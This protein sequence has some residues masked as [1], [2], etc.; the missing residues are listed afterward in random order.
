[1]HE[2]V[3]ARTLLASTILAG[4]HALSAQA[5]EGGAPAG[6]DEVIVTAQKRSENLQD[7]PM[8]I[9]AIGQ[10]TL[11]NLNV[12]SLDDYV[13][14]LP[15]VSYGQAVGSP[16]RSVIYMRGISTGAAGPNLLPNGQSP[17]VATY[18]DEI[19]T[20]TAS[21]TIDM[22]IYDVARVEALAGPQ[23]TLYGA[24]SEAGTLKIVT[25]PPDPS[26]F[27]AGYDLDGNV[28]RGNGLSNTAEGFINV[29]LADN[30]AIR[31]VG[32]QE[33]D[34][35]YIDNV[36]HTITYPS[37][38]YTV[39]NASLVKKNF[40][41]VDT[42]GGRGALKVDL[43][44][45]WTVLATLLGQTQWTSGFFGYSQNIGV[46]ETGFHLPEKTHDSYWAPALTI[47]GRIA[48]FDITWAGSYLRHSIYQ[49]Q[50]YTDYSFFYDIASGF[51]ANYAYGPGGKPIDVGQS[52]K[53]AFN[54][55]KETQEL[56]FASPA[57]KPLRVQGGLFYENQLSR[58][59]YDQFIHG[60]AP[61]LAVPGDAEAV[62][63][64]RA[65]VGQVDEAVYTNIAY[66]ILP[67][68]TIEAGGR[69]YHYNIENDNFSGGSVGFVFAGGAG[70]GRCIPG[71]TGVLGSPCTDNHLHIKQSGGT[72]RGSV[73][74]KFTDDALVYFTTSD[75]YRPGGVNAN[76][77]IPPY[78]AETLVNYE[79]G[80]K[81]SW[82]GNRL[83]WN[84]DMFYDP[85]SDFQFAFQGPNGVSETV[86][87]G[88]AVSEGIETDLTIKPINALT[89]TAAGSLI[90]AHLTEPYCG[91][92]L[93]NGQPQTDCPIPQAP[94]NTQLP[95]APYFK[96]N[97]VARYAFEIG[98]DIDAY[99]QS[100]TRFTGGS[101][102][103][104]Q[105]YI[106][107]QDPRTITG[108]NPAYFQEDVAAGA[109][110]GNSNLE[111]YIRNA[112]DANG[113]VGHFVKC[114]VTVCNASTYV[115]NIRPRTIGLRFGQRF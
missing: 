69:G 65:I 100:G 31:L 23:G 82:F 58:T 12:R 111:F 13:G 99:M 86:N 49:L 8:A 2:S 94:N 55:R 90:N 50:D 105:S 59:Y 109:N 85:W 27:A 108:R 95:S 98:S 73:T 110:W 17:T 53:E 19:P 91:K 42:Y 21:G 41:P 4:S 92:L 79:F 106:H 9:E 52:I 75:G 22:H 24:S 18:L 84:G 72:Y 7:V 28:G 48:D 63:E 87:A 93:A 26:K 114:P 20:T 113:Q 10:Q 43:N 1:M 39:N 66:D 25:N 102:N 47:T 54:F 81:S 3:L 36:F 44:E 60:V 62:W 14:L 103:Y 97:L 57:D 64:A 15:S 74:Y 34:S 11:E 67:D 80:W 6:L 70:V 32:Y 77:R 45:D 46:D 30:V 89:V 71:S 40:N 68:L 76:S 104:L 107:G 5:A 29:P 115:V 96:G 88:Q 51:A 78:L 33:H 101:W 112:F 61:E 38:G 16:G 56:R 83:R 37:T 35:G